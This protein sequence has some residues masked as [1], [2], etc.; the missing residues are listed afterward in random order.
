LEL[1]RAGYDVFV[2]ADAISSRFA[3]DRSLAIMR[4]HTAGI[5]IV[6]TE[7]V[8]FEWMERANT[9]L[10]KDSAARAAKIIAPGQLTFLRAPHVPLETAALK[11]R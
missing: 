2:V 1:K 7:M 6:S 5:W 3:D 11:V 9:R 10:F 8:L 4:M